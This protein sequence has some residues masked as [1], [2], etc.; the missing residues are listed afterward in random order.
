MKR[1]KR[2]TRASRKA[3][4]IPACADDDNTDDS[5]AS[6]SEPEESGGTKVYPSTHMGV[7]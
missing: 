5:V 1:N 6:W 7:A 2:T 4:E 3:R